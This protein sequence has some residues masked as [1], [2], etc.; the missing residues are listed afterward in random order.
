MSKDTI[1][2][3]KSQHARKADKADRFCIR[4]TVGGLEKFAP[5]PDQF[6]YTGIRTSDI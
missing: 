2:E 3:S 5:D 4:V 1:N 6:G